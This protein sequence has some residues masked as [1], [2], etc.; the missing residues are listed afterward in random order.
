MSHKETGSEDVHVI[1]LD[2]DRDKWRNSCEQHNES[3]GSI[4]SPECDLEYNSRRLYLHQ[5]VQRNG[6]KYKAILPCA[7][8]R[9]TEA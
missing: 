3:A 5:N 7:Y 4:S 6:R 9:N 1:N 8:L 2:L